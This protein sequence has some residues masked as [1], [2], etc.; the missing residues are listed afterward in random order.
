MSIL[1]RVSIAVKKHHDQGSSYEGKHLIGAGL[2][3]QRKHG[4]IQAYMILEKLRVLYLDPKSTRRT[5]T[6][7]CRQPGEG[8][9]LH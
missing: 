1:V 6:P 2:Q 9:L 3:F 8:Y 4:I 5:L 7:F